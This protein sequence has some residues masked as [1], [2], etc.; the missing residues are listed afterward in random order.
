M[1]KVG[2]QKMSVGILL[3]IIGGFLD[4]YTYFAR[5]G[6]F[7]NAQTGNIVKLG[8]NLA[9][10]DFHKV[11]RFLI[12]IICFMIGTLITIIMEEPLKK[13]HFH[14]R[15]I[16]LV[17]LVVYILVAF[18]PNSETGNIIANSLVSLIMAMQMQAFKS[19]EGLI[20]TTTVATGNLRKGIENMVYGFIQHDKDKIHSSYQFFQIVVLFIFGAVLGTWFTVEMGIKTI[21]FL[22]IPNAVCLI[23]ITLDKIYRVGLN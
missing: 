7:A 1:A 21:L 5:G 8:I 18:I 13:R 23:I 9:Q 2:S 17:E 10:G 14:K 16:L 20:Y 19:F 22:V 15:F 12:P 11:V 4:A 6:V 3:T